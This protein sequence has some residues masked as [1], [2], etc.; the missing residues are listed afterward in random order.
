MEHATNF[1]RIFRPGQ[2]AA[3]RQLAPHPGRLPRPRVDDRRQR[4]AGARGRPGRSRAGEFGA[5]ARARLRVRAR[6]RLRPVDS[7]PIAIDAREHIF[8]VVLLND[9]SARDIQRVRVRA[10][11][12]VPGQVVR[13][14]DLRRGSCRSTRS[15]PRASRRARRTRRRRRTCASRA[16]V[17]ARRRARGRAERRGRLAP[18]PARALLDAGA[19][20]RPPDGRTARRCRAGDL[21]AHRHDQR[22]GARHARARWPRSARGERWLADGDEVVLRGRAGDVELGRGARPGGAL[23]PSIVRAVRDLGRAWLKG[24]KRAVGMTMVAAGVVIWAAV[25]IVVLTGET[26]RPD[27]GIDWLMN[28]ATLTLLGSVVLALAGGRVWHVANTGET[29][30]P[31]RELRENGRSIE[32]WL[33]GSIAD[34]PAPRD[35]VGGASPGSAARRANAGSCA[36]ARRRNASASTRARWPAGSSADGSPAWRCPAERCASANGKSTSCTSASTPSS[37]AAATRGAPGS[38]RRHGYA[39]LMP[40]RPLFD[41]A[42]ARYLMRPVRAGRGRR[43]HARRQLASAVGWSHCI[44]V[45]PR[46]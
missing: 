1:G 5:D 44:G 40:R 41:A 42:L 8:G 43:R 45:R 17:G 6:L 27:S 29:F 13:D 16:A 46:A 15:T 33:E 4:D 23:P 38:P 24:G 7:R 19:D 3:A 12:A 11:R 37:R 35:D 36:A 18:E 34:R 39:A 28:P 10:A 21:F 20:A 22:R 14:V 2:A 9:W 26:T 31:G 32:R 30:W 25:M